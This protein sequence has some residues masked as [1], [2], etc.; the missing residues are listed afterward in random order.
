ML[1][2]PVRWTCDECCRK[3]DLLRVQNRVVYVLPWWECCQVYQTKVLFHE[4]CSNS[5]L[6][7]YQIYD[8][9]S[10]RTHFTQFS[11]PK[12]C[13]FFNLEQVNFCMTHDMYDLNKQKIVCLLWKILKRST[14]TSNGL[15]LWYT[16]CSTSTIF[17]R[18]MC[19]MVRFWARNNVLDWILGC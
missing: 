17:Q 15:F 1:Q 9:T 16:H 7:W 18:L 11:R 2:N 3:I 5:W 12:I 14:E 10:N 6:F 19:G 4:I 13:Q 8:C